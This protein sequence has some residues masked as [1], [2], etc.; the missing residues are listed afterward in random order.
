M[1]RKILGIRVPG[2]LPREGF[3]VFGQIGPNSFR[4]TPEAP[5]TA[6]FSQL[7]DRLR[8]NPQTVVERKTLCALDYF[9]A[10]GIIESDALQIAQRIDKLYPPRNWRDSIRMGRIHAALNK[11]EGLGVVKSQVTEADPNNPPRVVYRKIEP[12]TPPLK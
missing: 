12:P 6:G 3:S 5:K 2:L 1:E 11:L 4:T 10:E 7:V 9:A 8:S